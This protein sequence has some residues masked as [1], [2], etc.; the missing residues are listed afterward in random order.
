MVNRTSINTK[1]R[2]K[3]A[4]ICERF[5]LT[6]CVV[7]LS[8]CGG[9]ANHPAHK[10]KRSWYYGKE[11][12]LWDIKEWLPACI[13]CHQKIEGSKELTEKAFERWNEIH[14]HNL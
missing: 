2:K 6:R 5:N 10:H 4:E 3:I 8:G 7:R 9:E 14:L 12:L 11:E 1:A 13:N